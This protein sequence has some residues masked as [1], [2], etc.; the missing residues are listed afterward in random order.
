MI[1][2][3]VQPLPSTTMSDTADL[4]TGS[5]SMESKHTAPDALQKPQE[6]SQDEDE[7]PPFSTVI[8]TIAALML[9]SLCVS[10]VRLLSHIVPCSY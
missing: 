1:L 5:S 7:Y 4:P 2:K 8:I 6:P 9:T 10:L 3:A